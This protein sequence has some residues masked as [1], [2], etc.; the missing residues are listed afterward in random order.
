MWQLEAVAR[1]TKLCIRLRWKAAIAGAY[2]DREKSA[3]PKY[4]KNYLK[5]RPI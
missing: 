2:I 5:N 1:S 4:L 3:R